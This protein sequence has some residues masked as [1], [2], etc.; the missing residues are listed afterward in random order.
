MI[1][2]IRTLVVDDDRAA[3]DELLALLRGDPELLVVG[4]VGTGEA[5]IA[6]IGGLEPDLLL[7]NLGTAEPDA[8][9]LLRAL[10]GP[11]RPDVVFVTANPAYALHAFEAHALDYL[12]RPFTPERFAEAMRQ[13]KARVCQRRIAELG[14][15]L[16]ALL[17]GDGVGG[18]GAAEVAT[19]AAPLLPARSVIGD[20]RGRDATGA[21]IVE[22]WREP[23]RA[24]Y[25]DRIVVRHGRDTLFVS[26]DELDWIAAADYYVKLHTGGKSYL[27]RE[28]MQRMEARLD[29]RRFAR[30]HRS[31]IVNVDRVKRIQ[32]ASRGVHTVLLRDG[33]QLQMSRGRREM[34]E[35]A[36]GQPL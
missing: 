15:Q 4:D 27:V 26:I 9:A 28:T 17:Q 35:Q 23:P 31:T 25:V 6:M 14:R 29:P 5:A 19:V 21:R 16:A 3:R 8:L 36:L 7:L 11:R 2:P 12:L 20:A 1:Q 30:I 34:L 18:D 33:T 10:P 22:P 32:A 24:S 13:A